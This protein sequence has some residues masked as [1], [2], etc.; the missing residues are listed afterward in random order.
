MSRSPLAPLTPHSTLRSLAALSLLATLYQSSL[1]LAGAT[2]ANDAC[3]NADTLTLGLNPFT[4][5]GA[6]YAGPPVPCTSI[7][8]DVWFKFQSTFNGPLRISTC[9]DADFDTVIAVYSGCGC[10][11]FA[12]LACSDDTVGCS[13]ATSQFTVNVEAGKCYRIRVGGFMAASGTGILTLTVGDDD[14]AAAADEILTGDE[15]GDR[16]GQAVAGGARF[17]LGANED[18]LVGA[19]RNDLGANDIGRVYLHEGP[20]LDPLDDM[21][22]EFADD[23]FGFSVSAECD[24]DDDGV[25]DL[26]I[27]VPYSDD[28]GLNAGKVMVFS[29]FDGS[30]LWEFE[31]EAAGDRL[32]HSVGCAGDVNEDGFDDVIVGAPFNDT[33]GTSKGRAYVLNGVDGAAIYTKTG[34]SAGEQLGW[35]VD[36][37]GDLNNDGNDDFAVGSPRNDAG[38]ND[39]GRVSIFSGAT[40]GSLLKVNGDNAGDRFGTSISGMRFASSGPHGMLLIGAPYNDANGSNSGQVKVYYRNIGNPSQSG[41][42]GFMCI[43]YTISGGNPNDRFGSAVAVGNFHGS[44]FAD[45]AASGPLADMNG[46]SAG[47][48]WVFNGFSGILV[49]Q[50]FGE[51]DADKFGTSVANAGDVDDD[52]LDDLIV[53]APF[54]DAGG[55]DAGRAYLFLMGDSAAAMMGGPG[56]GG[57]ESGAKHDLN[58]DGVVDAVDVSVLVSGWGMCRSGRDLFRGCRGDIAPAGGDGVIDMNDLLELLRHIA[59]VQ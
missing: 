58:D 52:G 51:A 27:G 32:G 18:V 53:G 45:I 29:G 30:F 21:T 34:Q 3:A 7:G 44:T 1:C 46:T 17:N 8:A 14:I 57:D 22:G 49:A 20:N 42:G 47:A 24:V 11:N 28:T 6:T 33:G 26:I 43:R 37:V 38:G 41:C 59:I 12:L 36:G 54:N 35:A 5:V 48:A 39:A 23:Q 13:S 31:G 15:A 25:S 10:T 19:P 50:F 4:T 2:P 56:T 16:F 55:D 9:D 40:G